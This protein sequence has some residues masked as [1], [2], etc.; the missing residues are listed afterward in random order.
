MVGAIET[1]AKMEKGPHDKIIGVF[2]E[3]VET[4]DYSN[5]LLATAEQSLMKKPACKRP[6]AAKGVAFKKPAHAEEGAEEEESE[7]EEDSVEEESEEEQ[8][9]VPSPGELPPGAED[10]YAYALW[11]CPLC[12]GAW[13]PSCLVAHAHVHNEAQASFQ[14]CSS[15]AS[16]AGASQVS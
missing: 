9:E 14:T 7:E 15:H 16:H 12:S 2:P 10:G 1:R 11:A 5:L 4:V 8:D 3:G 6:A 13:L